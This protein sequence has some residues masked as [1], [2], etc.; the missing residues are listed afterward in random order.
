MSKIVVGIDGSESSTEALRWACV[1]A[2]RRGCDLDVVHAWEYRFTSFLLPGALPEEQMLDDG[3][4][5]LAEALTQL[6]DTGGVTVRT[7]LVKGHIVEVLRDLSE[8]SDLLVVASRGRGGFTSL[9]LGSVSASIAGH[10]LCPVAVVRRNHAM[11]QRIVVG[12]DGS[13]EA[14]HGLA[15]A[16]AE[17]AIDG[18]AVDVVMVVEPVINTVGPY[19]GFIIPPPIEELESEAERQIVEILA[20][21][22]VPANVTVRPVVRTGLAHRE[23][24]DEA[25]GASMLVV[26][27]RG[28][29]G[30]GLKIGSV[31]TACL[32]H[33]EGTPIVVVPTT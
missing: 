17:A 15:F 6:G 18:S 13:P 2:G 30:S 33:S 10:A 26:G 3:E 21:V 28:R 24:V 14:I 22:T 25:T 8:G 23:L 29:G 11:V 16:L 1:E 20:G 5:L 12:V 9:V 4:A 32:H 31:A 7:H 19:P 27:T